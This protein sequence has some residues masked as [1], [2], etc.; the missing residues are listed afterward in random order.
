MGVISTGISYNSTNFLYARSRYI[1]REQLLSDSDTAFI[2]AKEKSVTTVERGFS[3]NLK[4]TL[5]FLLLTML[6]VASTE[7]PWLY[8]ASEHPADFYSIMT[9]IADPR[10]QI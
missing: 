7:N 8:S 4:N 6:P 2:N 10:E 9:Q 1:R 5:P 3:S